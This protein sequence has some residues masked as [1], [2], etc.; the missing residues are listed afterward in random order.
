MAASGLLVEHEEALAFLPASVVRAVR[1][2]LVVTP[3]PGKQLGMALVN[4]KVIPVIYLGCLKHSL[5]ICE[6]DGEQF[7]LAGLTP[8]RSGFF[9]GDDE[10]PFHDGL[11][12]PQLALKK[13]LDQWRRRV[14]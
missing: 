5:I 11:P 8:V 9:D 10:Q 7:A 13:L 3:F 4:G 1:S 12:V 6:L 14:S 2:D